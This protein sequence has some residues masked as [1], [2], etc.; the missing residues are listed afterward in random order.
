MFYEI[1]PHNF[2]RVIN[3]WKQRLMTKPLYKRCTCNEC[4][5]DPENEGLNYLHNVLC[6]L[7][8][9]RLP[10]IDEEIDPGDYGKKRNI[11]QWNISS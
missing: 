1:L 8:F 6:F 3:R 11:P 10:N 7:S 5:P 9:I 4:D 2:E